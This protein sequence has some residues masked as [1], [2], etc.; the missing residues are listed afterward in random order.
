MGE[1]NSVTSLSFIWRGVKLEK[2]YRSIIETMKRADSRQRCEARLMARIIDIFEEESPDRARVAQVY[3]ESVTEHL[4]PEV[5]LCLEELAIAFHEEYIR[6]IRELEDNYKERGKPIRLNTAEGLELSRMDKCLTVDPDSRYPV[7][8]T[9]GDVG[10]CHYG[11]MFKKIADAIEIL[12]VYT[13]RGCEYIEWDSVP[14]IVEYIV[15]KIGRVGRGRLHRDFLSGDYLHHIGEPKSHWVA[16]SLGDEDFYSVPPV[17]RALYKD[18]KTHNVRA[19]ARA[20]VKQDAS[21]SQ[22]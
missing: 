5:Y 18:N 7:I 17:L 2:P 4:L 1:L 15:N 6:F 8:L 20:R 3:E 10:V 9:K 21:T 11:G 14:I 22:G 16:R 12:Y 19:R 13:T